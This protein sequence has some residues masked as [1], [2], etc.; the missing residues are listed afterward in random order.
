[1]RYGHGM[2]A[3]RTDHVR[4]CPSVNISRFENSWID[5]GEIWYGHYITN[6]NPKLVLST[7]LQAVKPI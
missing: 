6:D 1:M 4:V 5:F 2:N 3:N 7:F